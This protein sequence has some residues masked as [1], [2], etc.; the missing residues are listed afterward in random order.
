MQMFICI[1]VYI[2]FSK[3]SLYPIY[4]HGKRGGGHS[5]SITSVVESPYY[6]FCFVLPALPNWQTEM[7]TDSSSYP[8]RY[9]T[10]Y[11]M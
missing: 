6:T 11:M 5:S 8:A 3:S 9:L 4:W 2:S 1:R 10:A 7:P